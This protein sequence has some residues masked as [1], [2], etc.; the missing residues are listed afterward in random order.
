M[1]KRTRNGGIVAAGLLAAIAAWAPVAAQDAAA[2]TDED[3][4]W[5]DKSVRQLRGEYRDAEERF[6][7]AFNAVN[8]DD[9]FDMDCKTAPVLG[10]RKR[11]R[12]CQAEFLWDYEDEVGEEMYRQ[13]STGSPGSATTSPAILQRKQEELRAEMTAAISDYPD[14]AAAFAELTRTKRNYELKMAED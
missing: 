11:E 7:D 5:Q 13:S 3:M 2:V 10:S 6:Y 4:S 1:T 9:E 12:R 8:T 14:V